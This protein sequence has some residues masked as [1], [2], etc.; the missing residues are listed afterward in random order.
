MGGTA[1]KAWPLESGGELALL[2]DLATAAEAV[3]AILKMNVA[4]TGIARF[5]RWCR[6][7]IVCRPVCF[8]G[9]PNYKANLSYVEF[10][11]D[12]Y[13][14][15]LTPLHGFRCFWIIFTLA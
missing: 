10:V 8:T 5:S 13:L 9:G 15:S 3:A 6:A 4:F 7:F 2:G 1:T 14:Y 12:L 11:N